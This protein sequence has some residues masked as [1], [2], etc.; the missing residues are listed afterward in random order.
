MHFF[1]NF[2]SWQTKSVNFL[3]N[4]HIFLTYV[5]LLINIMKIKA[6]SLT[7]SFSLFSAF[8]FFS[9]AEVL[10]TNTGKTVSFNEIKRV[11]AQAPAEIK[12][13]TKFRASSDPIAPPHTFIFADTRLTGWTVIDA[14]KDGITWQ[15]DNK[16]D[17]KIGYNSNSAQDDWLISPAITLESGKNYEVKFECKGARFWPERVEVKYGQSATVEAMT[18]TAMSP[19]DIPDDDYA[20]YSCTISAETDGPHYIGFHCISDPDMFNFC[21]RSV[22]IGEGKSIATPGAVEDF[23]V[24]PDADAALKCDISFTTPATA[25]DGSVLSGLSRVELM[26]DEETIKTFENPGMGTRIEYTDNPPTGGQTSYRVIC[27]NAAGAGTAANLTVLVGFDRPAALQD[28]KISYT[29]IDGVIDAIWTPVTSD[30]KGHALGNEDVMY[31]IYKYDFDNDTYDLI[32]EGIKGSAYRYKAADEGSQQLFGIAVYPYTTAGPGDGRTSDVM[33]VGTPY[34]EIHESFADTKLNYIWMMR[35][36]NY[37][38][39]DIYDDTFSTVG[40][41][42]QDADNGYLRVRT[43]YFDSAVDIF[44]G[45]VALDTKN[46]TLSFYTLNLG[47]NGLDDTNT[48]AISV[49]DI[50]GDEWVTLMEPKAVTDICGGTPFA[51]GRCVVPLDPFAGKTVQIQFSVIGNMYED[52]MIDNITVQ[53]VPTID[54]S[55]A[56]VKFPALVKTGTP[57]SISAHVTNPGAATVSNYSVALYTGDSL[58]ESYDLQNLERDRAE[59]VKFDVYMSPFAEESDS[60]VIKVTCEG[61]EI[62]DNNI[63]EISVKPLVSRLPEVESLNGEYIAK[64]VNLS[65]EAPDL[66]SL[67]SELV[68]ESFEE[69]VGFDSTY[70]D[71]TFVDRDG[72]A[73]FIEGDIPGIENHISTGSFWVWNNDAIDWNQPVHKAK[74]GEKYLFAAGSRGKDTD[75]WAISPELSG[76][77]Q[78]LSFYAQSRMWTY[79]EEIEVYWSEGSVDPADFK[80]VDNSKVS[81]VAPAWTEYFTRLPQGAKRFAI[82]SFANDAWALML[83]DV[84][85][86]PVSPSTFTIT[87]YNIYR[88]G[89]KINETPVQTTGYSDSDVT[90][91]ETYSYQ[92]TAIY[93]DRGESGASTEYGIFAVIGRTLFQQPEASVNG[94]EITIEGCAG[95]PV[96]VTSANGTVIYNGISADNRLTLRAAQGIY[97]VKTEN[98]TTKVIVR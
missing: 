41:R 35:T 79:P 15:Y 6:L 95:Q 85:Y 59:T 61:D 93:G 62:A 51:W 10:K 65:W 19:T 8:S 7:L 4:C 37:G 34:S 77:S 46:P 53:G 17:A 33:P 81:P 29:D 55:M 28:V 31:S 1:I 3:E 96:W 11:T 73:V 90:D 44:T 39:V 5:N 23:T 76:E 74:T 54:L 57:Y 84:A 63:R 78:I 45:L 68:I 40:H 9:N 92:V 70:P 98:L 80:L 97:I 50:T 24:I 48:I 71:W 13:D 87:G 12:S 91:G 25:I 66:A 67:K 38:S 89:V 69:A 26:R 49:R 58:I 2:A 47:T 42:S 88:D 52:T 86:M 56:S 21:I 43:P 36:L 16:G 72:Y 20:E 64:T 22:S 82:R 32:E 18:K 60:F 75:N 94:N 83:D 30:L 27:Y 14:N